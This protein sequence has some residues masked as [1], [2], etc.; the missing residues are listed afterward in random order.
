M[1]FL[2]RI[3][4]LQRLLLKKAST[5]FVK[6]GFDKKLYGQSFRMPKPFG[7]AA[8]H[9]SFVSHGEIDFDVVT[10]VALR[11]NAVENIVQ[12]GNKLLSTKQRLET[13]TLGCEL[14]NLS[15][16]KQRRWTVAA[17]S[18]INPVLDSIETALVSI[19]LPY[20]EHYANQEEM[21][22]VLSSNDRS[23]WL[24]APLHH[25][26]GMHAVA[27]AIVLGK[28]DQVDKIIQ[29][30]ETLMKSLNDPNLPIFQNF[31]IRVAARLG[32]ECRGA[33]E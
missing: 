15:E 5:L 32:S 24:H 23:A 6:H 26:R 16:G 21:F 22:A 13:C 8:F 1:I 17:E 7:W 31:A 3:G 10:D 33:R 30:T 19:A 28:H 29:Q 4:H 2:S 25:Y 18:D 9:L 11:V 12:E 20:I 27:M 14:G